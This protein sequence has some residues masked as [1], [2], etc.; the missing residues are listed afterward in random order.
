[1]NLV[2]KCRRSGGMT[3]LPAAFW[4][5]VLVIVTGCASD[6][7]T[8]PGED[9]T[10]VVAGQGMDVPAAIAV[11]PNSDGELWVTNRGSD[12]IT[13]IRNASVEASV[14][15]RR[16]GYAVDHGEQ[17]EGVRCLAAPVFGPDGEIFA[18]ISLSGP[19]SRLNKRR[20]DGLVPD[21]KRIAADLSEALETF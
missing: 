10:T 9:I 4:C 17:E 7:T 18:S 12:S 13:I 3:V 8:S 14:E 20:L 19:A 6:S 5:F 1:M 16:D 2:R 21:L 11:R 15:I